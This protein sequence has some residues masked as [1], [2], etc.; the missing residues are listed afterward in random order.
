MNV[1]V[2][3]VVVVGRILCAFLIIKCKVNWCILNPIH[4]EPESVNYWNSY[5][6]QRHRHSF[7]V[8][9]VVVVVRWVFFGCLVCGVSFENS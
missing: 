9:V 1:I 2:V 3:V 4:P 6:Y 5:L 7:F 8:A